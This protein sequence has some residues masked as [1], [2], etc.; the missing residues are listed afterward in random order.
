MIARGTPLKSHESVPFIYP[1]RLTS[2]V[3]LLI[4]MS[5]DG[6]WLSSWHA[7]RSGVNDVE[8][9]EFL[10]EPPRRA[11]SGLSVRRF[12]RRRDGLYCPFIPRIRADGASEQRDTESETET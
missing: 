12:L 11:S 8:S 3:T 5:G 2:G 10:C 6:Y 1:A 7:F 4:K 9:I